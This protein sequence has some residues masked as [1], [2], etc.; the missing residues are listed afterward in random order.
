MAGGAAR[1][2][3]CVLRHAHDPGRPQP[4]GRLHAH[5]VHVE[6]VGVVGAVDRHHGDVRYTVSERGSGCAGVGVVSVDN[7]GWAE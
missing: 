6:Q 7:P 1:R 4:H 2:R 5:V 3:R